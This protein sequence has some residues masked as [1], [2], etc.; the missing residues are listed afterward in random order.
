MIFP[1]SPAADAARTARQALSLIA[2]ARPPA[3]ITALSKEVARYNA[4]VQHQTIQHSVSSPL[5]KARGEVLRIIEQLADK[6]YNEVAD[7]MIP[8]GDVL[9]HCL[10]T[11]LLKHKSLSDI[12]PPITKFYM[13]A[14]CANSRR[15][16]FG[17]KNGSVV[18]HELRAG[19]AQTISAHSRP[20]TSI[21]FSEDGKHLA[22][23]SADEAKVNFWQVSQAFLGMGQSQI[24]CVKQQQ[25]PGAFPV[26]TPGGTPQVFRAR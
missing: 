7:L 1:L 26:A 21:G 22:T 11:S 16:A 4:A 5:L 14:Y 13:V 15:I 20:V 18:L 25:A 19:K 6:Q 24:K 12:F 3:F 17:G 23:Y 8:V 9:V 10:D 2:N